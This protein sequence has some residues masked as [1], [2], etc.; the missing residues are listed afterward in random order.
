MQY[1]SHLSEGSHSI[2]G[3]CRKLGKLA[4]ISARHE[5][6]AWV[7]FGA[8][9]VDSKRW[10]PPFTVVCIVH[11]TAITRKARVEGPCNIL[12]DTPIDDDNPFPFRRLE[13]RQDGSPCEEGSASKSSVPKHT[14]CYC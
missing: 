10:L 5:V 7:S 3:G 4:K 8:R 2:R 13:C 6:D 9:I 14:I 11:S 1:R 12:T